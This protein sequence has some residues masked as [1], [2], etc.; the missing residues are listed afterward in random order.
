M[1]RTLKNKSRGWRDGLVVKV[2]T[3]L[4]EDQG[5]VPITHIVVHNNPVPGN[6]MPSLTFVGNGYTLHI[7]RQT[8]TIYIKIK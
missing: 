1:K 7:N 2:L 3:A 5:L 4:P 6:P 8:V